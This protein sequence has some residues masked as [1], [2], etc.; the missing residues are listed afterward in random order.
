M[1]LVFHFTDLVMIYSNCDP[2]P[3]RLPISIEPVSVQ[4]VGSE[5]FACTYVG[6]KRK[7]RK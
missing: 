7:M 5:E 2:F 1:P 3:L 6:R 4:T